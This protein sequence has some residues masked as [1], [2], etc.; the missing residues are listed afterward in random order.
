VFSLKLFGGASIL[1]P[2][3][4]VEG[5]A[6]QRRRLGLLALLAA[7]RHTGVGQPATGVSR[8][9]LISY[10]WPEAES[11]RG[12]H[13]L[14]DSVYR[15]NQAL[16]GDAIAAAGDEL[17]LNAA[18]L[19][20]DVAQLEDAAARGDH[21]RVVSLYTGPFLDGVFL[22]DSTEFERWVDSTRDRFAR[23]YAS[24]LETLAVEAE[25]AGD[26]ARAVEWWR[27]LATHDPLNARIAMRFMEALDAT[28][29][30]A[31]ALRHADIH[32]ALLRAELGAEPDTNVVAL[33][34]RLRS[35]PAAILAA[36][37][38]TPAR[39]RSLV[40]VPALVSETRHPPALSRRRRRWPAGLAFA[41]ATVGLLVVLS[42][43]AR[44][45]DAPSAE[46]F[47]PS[48]VVLPFTEVSEQHDNEYFG[49]GMTEELINTLAKVPDVHVASRT[50]AFVYKGRALDVREVGRRLGVATVLE[51]SVRK[52][53]S[54]LRITAR[55]VSAEDGY[56]LW[57]EAFERRSTDVFAVQEEIA[58][59]IVRKVRDRVYLR[60][61]LASHER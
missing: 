43:R 22:A 35:T 28:G 34:E 12:R 46:S 23:H 49:D 5:R 55:L 31:S 33:V 9:R 57:S 15:V 36:P 21:E 51:G 7:P 39:T 45:I 25:Q 11:D 24:S 44:R 17:R 18:I 40:H 29:A 1:S 20:S 10:L 54:K 60:G 48:I 8:E 14:S 52:S 3:G 56:Q 2:T 19:P 37:P 27:L 58:A 13:L 16:G 4:P 26:A 41:A 38:P 32:A 6:V 61:Q 30:R 47:G 53:G 42:A 50:S 59:A